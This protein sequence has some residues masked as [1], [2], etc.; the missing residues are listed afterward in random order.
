MSHV[1]ECKTVLKSLD[2]IEAAATRLGGQ[3]VRG[4]T[5]YRWYGSFV[6]DSTQW[7]TMFPDAEADRIARLDTH[8]R[9]AIINKEMSRCDHAISFPGARYDVGV[10]EQ[11]DGTYR[12]RWDFYGQG[13]LLK[14]MGDKTA[15]K[16]TQAYGIEA[17]K[18]AARRKGFGIKETTQDNG[19][20]ELTLLV[21]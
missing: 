12:L 15:G 19:N 9:R 21:M 16:F 10:V 8:E 4:K 20:V 18:R 17:A 3:L 14:F 7:K 13:G 5:T 2:D 1:A 11:P 6:D